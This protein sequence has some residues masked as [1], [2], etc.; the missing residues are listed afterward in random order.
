MTKNRPY[1]RLQIF[2]GLLCM[3]NYSVLIAKNIDEEN[4]D[5]IAAAVA[6]TSR[7]EEHQSRDLSRKPA[8]VLALANIAK[9]DKVAEIAA[10]SGYYT[11]LLSRV[12]GQQGKVYAI[13]PELIFTAFP[14]ARNTFPKYLQQDPRKNVE[15]SVQRLDQ[16]KVDE[17]V[18]SV[19]M[20]LY[21]HDTLWTD[22][23]REKM[24]QAIFDSLKP[25]GRFIVVDHHALENADPSVGQ[26]LHRM[27]ANI[28]L[29]EVPAA[30][31]RLVLDSDLLSNPDDPRTESVFGDW[32]GKT[33]RFIYIFEKP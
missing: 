27:D 6:D 9:R 16:L 22:E 10:G 25:G 29:A 30:G 4:I 12:V 28:V 20:I 19:L 5:Q 26:S 24:N 15:Y 7:L 17:P 18:D 3:L 14:D 8:E 2:L 1:N 23:N 32:R 31:F 33:D 11:A 13:D 21:Y